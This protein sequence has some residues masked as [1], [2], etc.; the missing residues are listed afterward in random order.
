MGRYLICRFGEFGKDHQTKNSPVQIIYMYITVPQISGFLR[1]EIY[2]HCHTDRLFRFLGIGEVC[3][4][5]Y[6]YMYKDVGLATLAHQ[7]E[8][9]ILGVGKSP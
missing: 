4:P 6:H 2:K 8:N 5:T 7:S 9:L 1:E 3:I